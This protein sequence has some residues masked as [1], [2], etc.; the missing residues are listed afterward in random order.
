M[1]CLQNAVLEGWQ[2]SPQKLSLDITWSLHP[3][4]QKKIG[5]KNHRLKE[6][7]FWSVWQYL[8]VIFPICWKKITFSHSWKDFAWYP[9]WKAIQT[10]GYWISIRPGSSHVKRF[11]WAPPCCCVY[12]KGVQD[13]EFET[14]PQDTKKAFPKRNRLKKVSIVINVLGHP[15]F[16]I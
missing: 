11:C 1:C 15:E 12:F 5:H 16:V 6:L 10:S 8:M 13:I 3:P 7:P 4:N 2:S 9:S 14:S